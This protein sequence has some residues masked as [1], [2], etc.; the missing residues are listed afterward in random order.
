[1]D[2]S[3]YTSGAPVTTDVE[4][5]ARDLIIYS[6]GIGSK[7]PRFVYENN[8]DFGAFPTYPIVLTFKGDS[9]DTLSF[10][11]PTMMSYPQA[12]LKGVKVGLDAEKFIEKVNELPKE[13]AKLKLVGS[14]VG[15]HKKGSGALVEQEFT[16]QDEQG[17]IYYRLVNGAFLVGAKDFT[18]SGKTFSKA[19]TPP[20]EAPHHTVETPTDVNIPSLY[21]LS[22]DYN[23]LH[24]DPQFA[25]MGGFEKPI[26][27]GQCTMGHVTRALLDTLVGGDAKRYK[28]IQLR[29]A[30]PVM[31]GET[32]VTEIWKESPTSF[33]FQTKVKETGKVCVNNGRLHLTPEGK[34]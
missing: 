19:A 6:L 18:D 5:N 33:I 21:R 31:P 3:K 11:S 27:H 17:K 9:F 14:T 16:L 4:Y 15:V 22:G 7:D 10:P 29:F 30:A 26:M 25:K 32:L 24:V 28:S 2:T 13:G 20:K 23:P 12:P 8:P 34:L 1:M